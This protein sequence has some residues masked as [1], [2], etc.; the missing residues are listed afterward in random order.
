MRVRSPLRSELTVALGLALLVAA[1]NPGL[2]FFGWVLGGYDAFVYFYPLRSYVAEALGQGRL[3]LW[4]PYLFAGSPYLANPQTAIFYPGT[5]LFALLDVP[6]AYAVNFLVHLWVAA[7]GFYAFGRVS[8]G[9]GR[10]GSVLGGA[11]FAFS[12]FMNGQAG[13]I[14]QFSVAAW[15]P[16]VAL[17]LD[18]A[19]RPRRNGPFWPAA[20]LTAGLTLQILAGHPQQVYMTVVALGLLVLWR[21]V[22]GRDRDARTAAD[23]PTKPGWPRLQVVMLVR[24]GVVLGVAA[25]LAGAIS[26][27]QLLPTLELSPLSI[28][29]GGLSYQIASFD[30][31]PWPL[32][33]PALFPGYWMHLPT[34]EF[35]GHLGTVVFGIAWL[36]L[37][38]GCGRAAALGALYVGLGLLL[39][40][41]DA[42][43]LYRLLFD[44][45]PG[46]ASFRVPARWLLVSTF[47]LAILAA[48]G[49]D[50]LLGWSAAGVAGLRDLLR[51]I[52]VA[53][54]AVAGVL[55]PLGLASLVVVG[56]PQSKWL[57][58]VWGLL[59][60]G[61]VALALVALLV[62]RARPATLSVLFLGALADLWLAGMNL[63]HRH[64]VPNVAYGQPREATTTLQSRMANAPG[65]RS[66]SIATPEYI[67]KETGEYEERYASASRLTLENL[68]VTVKWNE[69]LWPN[70]PLVHRVPS[71]DGYDGGVLPL[72]AYYQLTQAMLGAEQA[73]PDGVLASR[74]D[75][76]PEQRWL[77]LLGVRW[78][79]ASRVKDDAQG[80][81][82]YDR[83][84][85]VTLR[86]GQTLALGS[87]P[88]GEFTT[89]GLVSS[90]GPPASP[91]LPEQAS[92][93][94]LGPIAPG[95]VAPGDR[96]GT[97]RLTATADGTGPVTEVPIL[98]GIGT[99][100][101]SWQAEQAPDL[102]RVTAWGARGPE[103]P[104]DWI[105]NVEFPRQPV[106]RLEIVNTGQSSVLHVRAL[107]LIDDGRQMAF[108]IT[109]DSRVERVDFFDLKLYDRQDAL[110]RAYL[111][112]RSQ[113]VDD[114]A[115]AARL[116]VPDFEPRAEV[117]LA[118][119]PTARELQ[120]APDA[121]SV[122]FETD[123][124]ERVRLAVR[125]DAEQYLVL[126]DSWYPGWTATVDGVAVPIERANILFRAVAVPPGAH[127]VEFRY[128]P[129][130]V[131]IGA[132]LSAAGL[133]VA[134]VL[135]AGAF[136]WSRRR[137]AGGAS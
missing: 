69:T 27:V 4:N 93:R 31:L 47:G 127:M 9:L 5:W 57:L 68:L 17:A 76:M 119:S 126:S 28:R 66:L 15:V 130:S 134:A 23:L 8:L 89:L 97:L 122:T 55:V 125:T 62:P 120:A 90:L 53:R 102:E 78:V 61:T 129:R 86:P 20:G 59:M 19:M 45:A 115:V 64:P 37:L 103:A 107:N 136:V 6:H 63:E 118:S 25:G 101:E 43:P 133:A 70:V 13:H 75:A 72:R 35:F 108:P 94:S 16:A 82:Y 3:P 109:P 77:D 96:V 83:G 32:L 85:S 11:A 104:G 137:R 1:F 117:A 36:G 33:L 24:G 41:G 100:P 39:A 114:A 30:V 79:V 110:P 67:V 58:L 34:T 84:V 123:E 14:N 10:V 54:G 87:L 98:V 111:A 71:A 113:V 46:F 29:G 95:T 12:G 40:V 50:W 56:Q 112:G 81:I 60:A 65:F 38:A 99:A 22:G 48:A 105:A 52:G 44:W 26:A 132:M 74:L 21:S 116:S 135:A 18:L 106:G 49:G 7:L 88:L 131:Q 121:G 2:V 124:P 73:R 51:R 42:T 92:F 91:P 80:A 128:E